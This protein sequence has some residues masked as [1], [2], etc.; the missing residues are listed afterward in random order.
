MECLEGASLRFVLDES[1]PLPV[2]EVIPILANVG[3]A[4]QFLHAKRIIHG[5]FRPEAVFVTDAL[6]VKLLDIMPQLS[7]SR[8][9]SLDRRELLEFSYR[10]RDD[11]FGLACLTYELLSGRHP[12]N[13]NSAEEAMRAHLKP[14]PIDGLN[15]KPWRALQH[16][17]AFDSALRTHTITNV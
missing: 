3:R 1:G 6:E 15:E 4:A 7:V 10:V 11:V 9:K 17:M 16:G 14:L 12:F 2:N 8:S 5:A 13:S